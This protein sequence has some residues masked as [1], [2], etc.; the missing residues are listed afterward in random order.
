MVR[1]ASLLL[2]AVISCAAQNAPLTDGDRDRAMKLFDEHKLVDAL[3]LLEQLA[4][5]RPKDAVVMEHLGFAVLANAAGMKDAE[6]AKQERRRA[7]KIL[8]QAQALGDNSNLLQI[9]L[10]G[11]PEDGG[12]APAFSKN[13][14]VQSV[15][16]DAEAAFARGDLPQALDGYIRAFALDPKLYEAPVFAGDT[17]FKMHQMEPACEWYAR[18]V[19]VDPDRETAHRYWGDALMAMGKPAEARPKFLEAIVAE[20][21][22]RKTWVGVEQWA[23]RNKLTLASPKITPPNSVAAPSTGADGKT[24]INI[25]IDPSTLGK[26]GD[27]DGRSAWF[28]YSLL[29]ATWPTQRFA[30]EFPAEKQYRHSLKEE[31]ESLHMVATQ[32]RSKKAKHLDPQL[33]LLLKLDDAGLLEAYVLISA[34]DQGISQDYAAYRAANRDRLRRYLDEFVVPKLP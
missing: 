20:P 14:E 4:V 33:A 6:V 10:Q 32:A 22:R 16:R 31:S 25:T 24:N 2:A 8:L 12:D 15:M 18:A 7:R 30:K 3:P 1:I 28:I 9:L 19:A 34:A 29:R 11:I 17:Y 5:E 27:Q 21:Y 26:G 13:P 23:G